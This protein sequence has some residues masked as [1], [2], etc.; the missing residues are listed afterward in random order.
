MSEVSRIS[1]QL[2][3]H[4]DT[5]DVRLEQTYPVEP[6]ALWQAITAPERLAGWFA[7]VKG[8]LTEG[9]RCHV[10]FDAANPEQQINGTIEECAVGKRFVLSWE[11][12]DHPDSTVAATLSAGQEGTVLTLEHHRMQEDTAAAYGAGWQ[13]YLEALAVY[14]DGG[15]GIGERWD[16][17]WQELLPV[18]LHEA[19]GL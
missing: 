3:R 5:V 13:A 4:G 6:D 14:L 1:G 2:S 12:Q 9:G 17:R 15:S 8:E 7:V 18:Y 10:V 16:A 19:A 11:M